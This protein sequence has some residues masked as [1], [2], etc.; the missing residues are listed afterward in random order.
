MAGKIRPAGCFSKKWGNAAPCIWFHKAANFWKFEKW[1]EDG[2]ETYL[3]FH[4]Q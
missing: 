1:I 4:L 2:E 3:P